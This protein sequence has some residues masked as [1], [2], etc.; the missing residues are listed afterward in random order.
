MTRLIY[1]KEASRQANLPTDAA[2][3]SEA[4]QILHLKRLLVTLKQHYEKSLH[5][6]QIQLQVEQNQRITLQKELDNTHA[7]LHESQKLHE[8]ELQ[9]LRNQQTS[10]KEA[11][12]KTLD[13]LKQARENNSCQGQADPAASLQRLE[14]LES[15]IP[16]S[17]GRPD[18][19]AV[20]ET[21]KLKEELDRSQKK[22][23]TLEQELAENKELAFREIERMQRLLDAQ[24]ED[25]SVE[26]VVSTT[27]SHHLRQEL[28]AIKRTLAQETKALESR[29]V[30]ILNEKIGLDHQCKQLQQQLEHQSSNLTAFQEQ[31]HLMK[32]H[33]I[34][35]EE[36]LRAKETELT[37]VRHCVQE[38]QLQIDD[39]EIRAKEKDFVQDKYEQLKDEWNQLGDS[40]EEAAEIRAQTEQDLALL[41]ELS[42]KQESQLTE[43]SQQLQTLQEESKNVEA[44]RD[45]LKIL[46]DESETRLKVAQ[47]HLAKK[48]KESALLAERVEEQQNSLAEMAQTLD[49]QKTQI[50]QLQAS[51]DL[52]QRQEKRLQEQ[53]HDALKGTESQVAKWE[54]KYFRMYDKWQE[55]ET[56]IREL[57]KFEEKHLQ[58]QNLFA[59]LG[60]FMGSSFNHPA[61]SG[62]QASQELVE[63]NVRPP[64]HFEAPETES[65][66]SPHPKQEPD[67]ERYDLFGMRQPQDK[68]K[69]NP[70]S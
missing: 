12:K 65:I 38:M 33:K 32:E 64:L 44:D 34:K 31:L 14:Q 21:D 66:S 50:V 35:L 37:E 46:L 56:K 24:K 22:I 41:K 6:L 42:V 52:Y 4:D 40:L 16:Y 11:L 1:S 9:A 54:E 69:P 30:E 53:L 10:L 67:D 36:A 2:H 3:S 49:Q 25:V 20:G 70:Y 18:E 29:Y 47:Q 51:V 61:G 8:E 68:Y 5:S 15:A 48:V 27:S 19:A 60:N 39:L 26:T 13:D 7:Q 23:Y 28:E 17:R 58:M 55:S 59:N 57:K 45:Q 63:K 62:Y 43:L